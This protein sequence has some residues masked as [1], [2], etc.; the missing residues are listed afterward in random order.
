MHDKKVRVG[1]RWAIGDIDR[2]KSAMICDYCNQDLQGWEMKN[3]FS[4]EVMFLCED[5][6]KQPQ[7]KM[8]EILKI[9]KV[10]GKCGCKGL[11]AY[12]LTPSKAPR[13]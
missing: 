6:L 7:L 4:K 11:A 10:K 9:I 12:G 2:R 8:V 3:S 13:R 5:C 1:I